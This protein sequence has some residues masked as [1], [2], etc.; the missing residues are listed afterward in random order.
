MSGEE[1]KEVK[2]KEYFQVLQGERRDLAARVNATPPPVPQ[3]EPIKKEA[4]K[5]Q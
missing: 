1:K 3:P 4:R 5:Q 2:I